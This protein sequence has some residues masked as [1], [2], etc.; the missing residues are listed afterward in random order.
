MEDSNYNRTSWPEL[1]SFFKSGN[2]HGLPL[3][4]TSGSIHDNLSSFLLAEM[5]G[6]KKEGK[7]PL[8]DYLRSYARGDL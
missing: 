3:S 2:G 8:S 5:K 7:D 6:V 1:E 4:V